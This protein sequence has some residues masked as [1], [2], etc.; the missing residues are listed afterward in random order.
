MESLEKFQPSFGSWSCPASLQKLSRA[1]ELATQH[2]RELGRIRALLSISPLSIPL[3]KF[4]NST[5][6]LALSLSPSFSL[7]LSLLEFPLTT[8]VSLQL[9]SNGSQICSSRRVLM[10]KEKTYKLTR[11]QSQVITRFLPHFSL[12]SL[13]LFSYLD[14]FYSSVLERKEESKRESEREKRKEER[15]HGI[16][17]PLVLLQKRYRLSIIYHRRRR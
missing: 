3:S 16:G 17:N 8:S 15:E 1:K 14:S 12:V 10:Y 6:F 5:K 4:S 9:E 13:L 7:L 2:M 11:L